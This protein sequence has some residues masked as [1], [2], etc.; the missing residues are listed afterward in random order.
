MPVSDLDTLLVRAVRLSPD[1]RATLIA[2][3]QESL[4][5]NDTP[6]DLGTE[7]AW[8]EECERRI[9]EIDRGE[10]EALPGDTFFDN[11]ARG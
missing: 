2:R 5:N 3:L 10:V 8:I 6:I 7:A 1:D 11:P 4:Q 9:A